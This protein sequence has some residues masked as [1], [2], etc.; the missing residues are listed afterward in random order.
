MLEV[1]GVAVVPFDEAAEVM[2]GMELQD[3]LHFAN[4]D[5]AKM[6]FAENWAEWLDRHALSLIHI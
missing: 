5:D 2:E 1:A 6:T 3:G 4:D